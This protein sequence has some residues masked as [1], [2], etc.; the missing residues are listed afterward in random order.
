MTALEALRAELMRAGFGLRDAAAQPMDQ[1]LVWYQQA[2]A[3]GLYQPRAATLATVNAQ[4]RPAA[5]MIVLAGFETGGIDFLTDDRS[6][7]ADDLRHQPWAALVFYWAELERQVRIEGPVAP[8]EASAADAYFDRRARDSKLSAWASRQSEVIPDRAVIEQQLLQQLTEHHGQ[9]V[10]RPDYYVAYRLR[11]SLL[12][13][14][15]GR[16]DRLSDRVR[17]RQVE[18]NSWLIELLS[19]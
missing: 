12:E 14:W 7:K 18:N 6:P 16:D 15:Q 5:R 9:P 10:G 13:F 8:L 17:Y 4:G 11:P 19:P 1:F 3:A 2:L